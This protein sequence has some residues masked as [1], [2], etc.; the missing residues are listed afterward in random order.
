MIKYIEDG[1]SQISIGKRHIR[2]RVVPNPITDYFIFETKIGYLPQSRNGFEN[3]FLDEQQYRT[4]MGELKEDIDTIS[5]FWLFDK[6][7]VVE[8]KYDV[9]GKYLGN[10]IT[11][12]CSIVEKCVKIRDAFISVSY[13]FS[14]L[15]D[16]LVK[17]LVIA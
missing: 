13:P 8:M 9:E 16:Q 7:T 2:A 5:D 11:E 10:N 17:E 3:I 12:D 4:L 15:R 1:R 6:E 14:R